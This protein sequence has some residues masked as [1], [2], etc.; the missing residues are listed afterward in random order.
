MAHS[1]QHK[2]LV[3]AIIDAEHEA[4]R[5]GQE[6]KQQA[7]SLSARLSQIGRLLVAKRIAGKLTADQC[8]KLWEQAFRDL[9][10]LGFTHVVHD[11]LETTK[12]HVDSIHGKAR[13]LGTHVKAMQVINRLD[14]EA[15]K[16]ERDGQNNNGSA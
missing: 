3:D 12:G 16:A 15:R 11:L 6:V 5:I 10:L 8:K 14:M 1:P 9:S 4:E 2:P 7:P 13:A